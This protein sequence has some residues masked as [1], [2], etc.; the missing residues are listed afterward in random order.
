MKIHLPTQI[1]SVIALTLTPTAAITQPSHGQATKFFCGMS[2]GM[3]ATFVTTSR[4][5]I[6]VITWKH[7]FGDRW[8]PHNRCASIT[9]R[10]NYFYQNGTLKYIRAGILRNHPVLCVAS[11]KGGDCLK[12]GVLIT[13]KRGINAHSVLHRLM[14]RSRYAGGRTIELA[15]PISHHRGA[16]YLDMKKLI[17]EDTSRDN[18]ECKGPVWQC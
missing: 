10:F 2:R 15:N 13:L 16:S 1:L 6:P 3:P 7:S 14:H 4:G 18:K 17:G 9:E 12:N 5:N 8:T 11:Y